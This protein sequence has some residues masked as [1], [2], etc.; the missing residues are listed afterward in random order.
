MPLHIIRQDIKKINCD[1]I[2]NTSN[3]LMIGFSGVDY[4][5]HQAAGPELDKE[6]QGILPL[7]LGFAKITKGYNLACKYIIHTS[8]P[9]W[10]GGGHGEKAILKSCYLESLKLAKQN[11]CESVAFPLISS[12]TYGYPKDQVLK[13]AIEVITEFLYE[14]EMTVYLCVYDKKS[15]EFSKELFEDIQDF[16]DAEDEEDE[17][18]DRELVE[19]YFRRKG[20]CD[21]AIEIFEDVALPPM[22]RV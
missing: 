7:E 9:V 18:S 1:A 6:C 17:E 22:G 11:A 13:F 14:N 12:G 16:I 5:I 20:M 8:G 15:Y 10:E 4:A 3:E 21:S 19:S 2:V